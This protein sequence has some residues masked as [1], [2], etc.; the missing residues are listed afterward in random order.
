MSER[1]HQACPQPNGGMGMGNRA[2]FVVVEDSDRRLYNAG[3]ASR[4]EAQ[5]G[6]AELLGFVAI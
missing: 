5:R 6:V 2:N 3:F 1:S 4:D